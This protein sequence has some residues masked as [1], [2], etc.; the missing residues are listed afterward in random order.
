[1]SWRKNKRKEEHTPLEE[2]PYSQWLHD[3]A[4]MLH[5]F[6]TV[7]DKD[8]EVQKGGTMLLFAEGGKWKVC[9]RDRQV[10]DSL[11]LSFDD[12]GPGLLQE[13]SRALEEG[14]GSW[15]P[16]QGSSGRV[17]QSVRR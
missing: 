8:F 17:R 3:N 11:W 4:Q 2:M 6:F 12:L 13:V 1:M 7:L 14:K 16:S 10:N 15:R 9:L 5:E